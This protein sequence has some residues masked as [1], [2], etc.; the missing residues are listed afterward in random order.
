MTLAESLILP[1][2]AMFLALAGG[3]VV[4]LKLRPKRGY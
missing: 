3:V 1:T 2:L 4:L